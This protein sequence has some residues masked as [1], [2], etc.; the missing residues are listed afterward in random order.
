MCWRFYMSLHVQPVPNWTLWVLELPSSFSK[1]GSNH[2]MSYNKT[3]QRTKIFW[4]LQKHET[5]RSTLHCTPTSNPS[6]PPQHSLNRPAF[7]SSSVYPPLL[8]PLLPPTRSH[9]RLLSTHQRSAQQPAWHEGLLLEPYNVIKAQRV[10]FAVWGKLGA[11]DLDRRRNPGLHGTLDT[12][13]SN[14]AS[15]FAFV[16]ADLQKSPLECGNRKYWQF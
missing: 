15:D 5:L 10:A 3:S 14:H 1:R 8:P 16:R 13:T 6:P 4:G 12:K 9:L 7:S 11:T 2:S